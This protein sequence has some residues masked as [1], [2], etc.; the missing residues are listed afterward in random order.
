MP[1]VLFIFLQ[2]TGKKNQQLIFLFINQN[3]AF[4]YTYFNNS[5]FYTQSNISHLLYINLYYEI[6]KNLHLD[7]CIFEK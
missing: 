1:K 3:K 7:Y 4:V 5:S 6:L 2:E